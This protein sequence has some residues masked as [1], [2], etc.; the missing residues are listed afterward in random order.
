M[1]SHIGLKI[2]NLRKNK[3]VSGEVL[4]D[5]IGV[6]KGAVSSWERGNATPEPLKLIA[7]EQYFGL[8]YGELLEQSNNAEVNERMVEYVTKRKDLTMQ[9]I[10]IKLQI[11]G[12]WTHEFEIKI[13]FE[14]TAKPRK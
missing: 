8:E 3:G 12:D 10:P 2:L 11:N 6:T 7:M 14:I 9:E 4:G 5:A 1:E 13:K